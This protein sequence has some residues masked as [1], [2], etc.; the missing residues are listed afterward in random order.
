[1]NSFTWVLYLSPFG[2]EDVQDGGLVTHLLGHH[3]G[4]LLNCVHVRRLLELHLDPGH[5]LHLVRGDVAGIMAGTC[6]Y[7]GIISPSTAAIFWAN[8]DLFY[9]TATL[10]TNSFYLTATLVSNFTSTAF[11]NLTSLTVILVMKLC[12]WVRN[13]TAANPGLFFFVT[14]SVTMILAAAEQMSLFFL[15]VEPD[16]HRAPSCPSC[17]TASASTWTRTQ[18]SSS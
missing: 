12:T 11:T 14:V 15:L 3:G 16:Q 9:L 10:V 7:S 8:Q 6:G 4:G 2:N 5:C 13:F 18:A 17:P 1:M